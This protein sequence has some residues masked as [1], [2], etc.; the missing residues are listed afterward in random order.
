MNYY[1]YT[2]EESLIG[3]GTRYVEVSNRRAMREVTVNGDLFLGSN[4]CY[5]RWGLILAEGAI[6]YDGIEEIT[7]ISPEEFD[8]VWAKHLMHNAGRWAVIKRAY[9]IDTQVQGS[10]AAFFPQGVIVDLGDS[11]TLGVAN[12]A[13]C[14]ASTNP[15]GIWAKQQM[16]AVVQGYDELNHWL[17][18]DKPQVHNDQR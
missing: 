7:A 15:K 16:S 17:V 2:D 10:I 6:D 14:K 3:Q 5:P 12:Y 9:P 4:I 13:A 1:K 8:A 11:S 18:L